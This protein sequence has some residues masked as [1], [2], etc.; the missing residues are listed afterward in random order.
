MSGG[1]ESANQELKTA[2][3]ATE[4]SVVSVVSAPVV[5]VDAVYHRLGE[6]N[7]PLSQLI[8]PLHKLIAEYAVWIN[9]VQILLDSSRVTVIGICPAPMHGANTLTVLEAK[10]MGE[11]R[12]DAVRLLRMSVAR[13]NEFG[14]V[15][16]RIVDGWGQSFCLDPINPDCY[17]LGN[18][19]A[20]YHL[21]P[22]FSSASPDRYSVRRICSQR[23]LNPVVCM[24]P[25]T[26]SLPVPVA[27]AHDTI[28]CCISWKCSHRS[29]WL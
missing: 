8:R 29:C 1:N 11:H 10:P 26:T 4:L 23:R 22:S 2:A 13:P 14:V 21:Q 7:G 6:P 25:T 5:D 17:Y 20:V 9:R 18:K 24:L 15:A 28:D 3:A 19:S 27:A 12:E 16:P